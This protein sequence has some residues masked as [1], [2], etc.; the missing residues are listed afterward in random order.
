MSDLTEFETKMLVEVQG[1][2]RTLVAMALHAGVQ[3]GRKAPG[4]GRRQEPGMIASDKDLD[5]EKGD[6]TV[7][8]KPRGWEGTT[9]RAASTARRP[10]SS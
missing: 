9:S 2:R 3:P 7:R 10:P 1:I 4:E 6:P 8:F 5:S